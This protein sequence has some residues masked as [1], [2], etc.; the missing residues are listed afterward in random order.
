MPS[1]VE[2]ASKRFTCLI[3]GWL[4]CVKLSV[5][6]ASELKKEEIGEF[7]IRN[8]LEH[9]RARWWRSWLKVEKR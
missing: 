8:P 7:H 5:D 4:S 1:Q 6:A 2:T 3:R 9:L